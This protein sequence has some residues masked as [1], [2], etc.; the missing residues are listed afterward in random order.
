M[1]AHVEQKTR[2]MVD[3]ETGVRA[4]VEAI[5]RRRGKAYVPAWPWVPIGIAMKVLPLR[6]VR[7]L[8]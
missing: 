2:F 5:E 3:T 8:T 7:R 6:I 4:M 1:N